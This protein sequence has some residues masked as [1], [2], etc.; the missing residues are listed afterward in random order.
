MIRY[1]SLVLLAA[2][3]LSG[4]HGGFLRVKRGYTSGGGGYGGGGYG[5]GNYVLNTGVGGYGGSTNPYSA[6]DVANQAAT[7]AQALAASQQGASAYAAQQAAFQVAQQATASADAANDASYAKFAQAAQTA[8]ARQGALAKALAEGAQ[9][10]LQ[11]SVALAAETQK[12][13][14][15]RVAEALREA[16]AGAYGTAGIAGE[17]LSAALADYSSQNQMVWNAQAAAH[18]LGSQQTL[19]NA[20]LDGAQAA[21]ARA[22]AAA[23]KAGARASVG[24]GFGSYH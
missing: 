18:A 15:R 5:G 7:T 1:F 10:Q 14:A 23:T 19:A 21:A 24:S 8:I 11:E 17:T 3:A 2:I 6:G 9:R 4:A 16:E 22:T 12:L 13:S 20:D